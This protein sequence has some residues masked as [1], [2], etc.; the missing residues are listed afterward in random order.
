MRRKGNILIS[1][2][3][4]LIAAALA[5]SIYNVYQGQQGTFSVRN[6]LSQLETLVQQ[7]E[8]EPNSGET[9]AENEAALTIAPG[10]MTFL[11]VLPD[12]L[13]NPEMEMP[14]CTIDGDD[15]I[16]VLSIPSQ[17]LSLPVGSECTNPMLRVAPCR[18][19]GSAYLGN[20]VICAHNYRGFFS[21]IKDLTLGAQVMFTDV[22]G[23]VFSYQVVDKEILQ[24]ENVEEM[25]SGDWDMTLFTC[26][27][28]GQSRVAVRLSQITN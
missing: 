19:S 17:E 15:Y 9:D 4:L 18:Y 1:M 6:T 21:K 20:L 7:A 25:I 16:G 10:E 22:D 24:P 3:L 28:G 11:E 23:N 14:V 5:V 2:G 8:A 12:Y 13:Q 27:V 26:T